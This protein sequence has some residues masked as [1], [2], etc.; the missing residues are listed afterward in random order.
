M[1]KKTKGITLIALIITIIVLLILAGVTIVTLTGD[2]GILTHAKQ[3]KIET[4]QA[5]IK[6]ELTIAMA[7]Y[8]IAKSQNDSLTLL[9]FLQNT[10]QNGLTDLKIIEQTSKK[11][12]GSYQERIFFIDESGEIK[13]STSPNLFN[14]G[15]GEEKNN[16]NFSEATF[17]EGE[18]YFSYLAKGEKTFL[19]NDY[20]PVDTT[21][22]YYQA[23]TARSNNPNSS[24]Y[25]GFQEYDEDKNAIAAYHF[26]SRSNSLTYLERDLKKG[27]TEVY[28]HDASGFALTSSTPSWYKGFIFWNYQN[29]SG[30]QYPEL[31]YSRNVFPSYDSGSLFDLEDIDLTNHIIHLKEPW[32]NI[33]MPKGTKVSQRSSGS[34]WNYGLRINDTLPNNWTTL[35]NTIQGIQNGASNVNYIQFR[36]GTKYVRFLAMVNYAVPTE[37]TTFDFK[38][39]IFTQMD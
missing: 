1:G 14:N 2:N 32:N 5:A 26:L 13:I 33:T 28:L 3:A 12:I 30:Y 36:P 34:M 21:K 38:N 27:D 37:E 39:V 23:V 25:I 31:T 7:N 11:I 16:T 17:E 19:S 35:G 22:T 8:E 15:L 24:Y 9:D 18:G 29:N 20:I 4:E 10:E 6:E